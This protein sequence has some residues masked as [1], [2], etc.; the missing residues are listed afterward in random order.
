[1]IGK[2][3]TRGGI[4]GIGGLI[5][6]SMWLIPA[7]ADT[8]GD[9]P[10]D[11][12]IPP[13]ATIEPAGPILPTPTQEESF[14][15]VLLE[16]APPSIVSLTEEGCCAGSAWSMDSEWVLFFDKP[17]PE[18]P[19]GLYGVPFLGGDIT[20]FNPRVGSYS[21]D[22]SLVAYNEAGVTYVERWADGSRWPIS[23]E[24]RE[25]H[26][27]PNGEHVLWEIGSRAITSPDRRQ[28]KSWISNYDGGEPREL[29]TLH[30]GSLIGWIGD[31]SVLVSGRLAPP[32]PAGLWKVSIL[33]GAAQRLFDAVNPRSVLLSPNGGWL[34]ATVA[35]ENDPGRNGI[36]VVRT[37]GRLSKKIPVYGAYRWR[38]DNQLLVIPLSMSEP[39]PYVLQFD[40]EGDRIWRITDPLETSLPIANNDWQVSPDGKKM[41]FLSAIDGNLQVLYLPEP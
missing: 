4:A 19:A 30:G 38:T 39:D 22:W 25:V 3:L 24:G 17:S 7:S 10:V 41:V 9:R 33:D 16:Q 12:R 37:D 8:R 31:D 6:L 27:S 15:P 29:L 13:L 23:S 36:W 32:D 18:D 5:V 40:L 35:F 20:L 11:R 14:F 26:I 21:E 34:A 2:N 1:M 28:R